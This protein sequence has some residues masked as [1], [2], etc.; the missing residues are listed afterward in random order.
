[1]DGVKEYLAKY[2]SLLVDVRCPN[3]KKLF[4][5]QLGVSTVEIKCHGCKKIWIF[6]P[7]MAAEF[8]WIDITSSN[9]AVQ[10]DAISVVS[11]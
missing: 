6:I 4:F 1:M 5:R 11:V 9:Q 10:I 8:S 7:S 3:C 2:R